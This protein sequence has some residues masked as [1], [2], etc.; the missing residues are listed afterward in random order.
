MITTHKTSLFIKPLRF[1]GLGIVT[2]LLSLPSS[3]SAASV[4]PTCSAKIV[5]PQ[6]ETKTK[7]ETEVSV[8]K[9]DTITVSWDSKNAK[10]AVDADGNKVALSGSTTV[11]VNDMDTYSYTFKTGSKKVTCSIEASIVGGSID[12]SSLITNS[13]KPKIS[14]TASGTKTVKVTVK[15]E[16]S[17]KT[18]LNKTIKVKNGKWK[19]EVTKKLADGRYSVSVFSGDGEVNLASG[20]LIVGKST[21]NT[22]SNSNSKSTNSKSSSTLSVSLVPLLVGGTAHAGGSVPVSYLKVIN[23]GK[24]VAV[25]KG[26]TLKQNGNAGDSAIIGLTTVDDKNGSRTSIG[27]VEGESPFKNGVATI[28]MDITFAPDQMLIF[29]I[30][31]GLTKNI[32]AYVGKQLAIEVS[33]IDTNANLKGAFPIRGTTWNIAY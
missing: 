3:A 23:V 25:L 17:N 29:T 4:K 32:S 7:K 19:A 14:G 15:A 27:G 8:I 20:T 31:A 5:T 30:K 22:Q 11:V 1:V 6:G 10:E 24:E 9:G 33:S 26:I 18:Y 12:S 21:S 16:D 2:L 28:P 13:S